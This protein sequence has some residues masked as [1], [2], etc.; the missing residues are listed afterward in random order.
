MKHSVDKLDKLIENSKR[1]L[2]LSH[3]FPDPDAVTSAIGVKHYISVKFK[4][5]VV[6]VKI[7]NYSKDNF[8]FV[9]QRDQISPLL[10][11]TEEKHNYD[12]FV[13]VDAQEAHMFETELQPKD[14]IGL[15]IA[16]IDHHPYQNCGYDFEYVDPS[17]ASCADLIFEIL[18]NREIQDREVAFTLFIGLLADSGSLTYIKKNKVR[19]LENASVF[20]EQF[21]F[22]TEEVKNI[23]TEMTVDEFLLYKQYINNLQFEEKLQLTISYSDYSVLETYPRQIVKKITSKFLGSIGMTIKNHTWAVALTPYSSTKY[24]IS[25]RSARGGVDVSE[26]AKHFNRGGHAHAAAGELIFDKPTSGEEAKDFLL[27]KIRTLEL[28]HTS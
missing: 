19:S 1:I 13:F 28:I 4:D 23:F 18:F 16:C 8:A 12:L 17:F 7:S 20:I 14:L 25:F 6:D 5:K 10:S 11:F 26:L 21:D 22:N 27:D 15:K 24:G 3:N 2:V 9:P